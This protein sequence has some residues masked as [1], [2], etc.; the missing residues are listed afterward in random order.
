M[1]PVAALAW[2]LGCIAAFYL[3]V[4]LISWAIR[5]RYP[6]MQHLST[7]STGSRKTNSNS[8]STRPGQAAAMSQEPI[9]T[10][11]GPYQRW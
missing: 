7:L 9:L 6:A 8:D 3:V 5:K 11:P 1:T 2:F 4:R 10:A